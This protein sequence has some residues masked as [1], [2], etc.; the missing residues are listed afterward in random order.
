M[1]WALWRHSSQLP[2]K[3][4]CIQYPGSKAHFQLITCEMKWQWRQWVRVAWWCV[5]LTDRW[6]G[7]ATWGFR[8]PSLVNGVLKLNYL[9]G[10]YVYFLALWMNLSNT[11][12]YGRLLGS[13]QC[14]F[15]SLVWC[16]GF[17]QHCIIFSITSNKLQCKIWCFSSLLTFSSFKASFPPNASQMIQYLVG[18]VHRYLYNKYPIPFSLD[19][20]GI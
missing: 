13:Y 7:D 3:G 10:L 19:N 18:K 4:R 8:S 12:C 20:I 11:F 6:V 14:L 9:L 16:Q 17:N 15:G 1:F 5:S 2:H